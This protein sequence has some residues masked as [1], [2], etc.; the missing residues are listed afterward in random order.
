M[1]LFHIQNKA[2][3]KKPQFD[4][5]V[6]TEIPNNLDY[7]SSIIDISDGY[8]IYIDGKPKLEKNN[9]IINFVS[10]KEK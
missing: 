4:K 7:Q 6:S 8:S 1:L 5:N 10:V 3:F 2:T 9:L